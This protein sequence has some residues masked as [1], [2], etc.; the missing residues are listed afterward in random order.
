LK[1][2]PGGLSS[3]CFREDHGIPFRGDKAALQ[4]LMDAAE[5]AKRALSEYTKYSVHLPYVTTIDDKSYDLNVDLDRDRMN[6]LVEPLVSKCLG[7]IEEVLL[8]AGADPESINDVL[9]VGG[10]TRMLFVRDRLK[11]FFGVEPSKNVHPDEAVALGAAILAHADE[12]REGI[13]L[14]DVNPMSIGIK[15]PAGRFKKVIERNTQLPLSKS[16]TIGTTKKNQKELQLEVFQGEAEQADENEVLGTLTFSDLPKG[17]KGDV[18][19]KVNF[20]L[21][22]EC[23]LTLTAIEESTGREVET[24]LATKGTPAMVLRKMQTRAGV[25]GTGTHQRPE[26]GFFAW[27]KRLFG[28]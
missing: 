14:V 18:R 10:S 17:E 24:T 5:Q 12:K 9:L 6:S 4:R 20:H 3:Q 13:R 8:M 7:V 27:L 16:Y 1:K 23:I 11:A 19:M 28:R 25:M 22:E 15:L 26:L 2:A 21:S